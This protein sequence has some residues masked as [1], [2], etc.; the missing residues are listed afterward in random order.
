MESR[1]Y[2]SSSSLCPHK[3]H[4]DS[5]LGHGNRP[6]SGLEALPASPKRPQNT[7]FGQNKRI[8][9]QRPLEA[10][11]MTIKPPELELNLLLEALKR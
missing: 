8:T 3:V 7:P 9:P 1:M 6:N 5:T 11:K 4:L 2:I 10:P